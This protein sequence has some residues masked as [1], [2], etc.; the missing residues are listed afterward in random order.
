MAD[1]QE[2][3]GHNDWPHLEQRKKKRI[4]SM[5][6]G[7]VNIIQRRSRCRFIHFF[8]S[9]AIS[10]HFFFMVLPA[11]APLLG[12]TQFYRVSILNFEKSV[13]WHFVLDFDWLL[14]LKN[15]VL[16][17]FTQFYLVLPSFTGFYWVLPG[18]NWVLPSYTWFYLV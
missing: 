5:G 17:G 10:S 3:T 13:P 2:S 18:C 15:W 16:P 4:S 14:S 7:Q 12:F 9:I 8:F 11:S 6:H 1:Q